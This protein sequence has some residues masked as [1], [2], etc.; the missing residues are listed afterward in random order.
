MTDYLNDEPEDQFVS[1]TQRKK[2]MNALQDLGQELLELSKEQ[3]NKIGLPEA[4]LQAI[5]EYKRITAHGARKR[6]AQYIGRLMRDIDPE[7]IRDHLAIR[8]GESAAHTGW[9]HQIERWRDR[10]LEDDNILPGFVEQY[11]AADIQQLRTLIRNAR[12]EKAE[13]RPP[14]SCRQLF[15][16]IKTLLPEPGRPNAASGDDDGEASA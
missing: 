3:L 8:R 6:Q 5:A 14:K 13:A 2:Q 4:L 11:P 9:L 16:E 1:K 7:P 12:R 15:Q 10:L